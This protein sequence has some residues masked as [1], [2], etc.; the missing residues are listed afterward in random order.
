MAAAETVVLSCTLIIFPS[1][2]VQEMLTKVSA[3]RR[4]RQNIA[5]VT[6]RCPGSPASLIP[7]RVEL[8]TT[9]RPALWV[10]ANGLRVT[11]AAC[12]II[13][14]GIPECL[15][16]SSGVFEILVYDQVQ[17]SAG[18][19]FMRRCSWGTFRL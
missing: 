7:E 8:S 19:R 16:R 15:G 10:I 2:R 3:S 4:L 9:D 18:K 6:V 17:L 12:I 11:A 14:A 1:T 5:G 13:A